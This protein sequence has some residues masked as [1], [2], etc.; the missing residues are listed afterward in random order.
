MNTKQK[1]HQAKLNQ[2]TVRFQEQA[3]SGLTVKAW[4]AENNITIHT[5]NYWKHQ[6]K[7]EYADS[8]LPDIVPLT[9]CQPVPV[10]ALPVT[11]NH[12]ALSTLQTS[13]DSRELHASNNTICIS[14][15][16]IQIHI[17]SSVSV[18]CLLQILKA[19]R[20]A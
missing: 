11:S 4:C 10:S 3:S 5:Y 7:L 2:W 14:T 17:G 12:Q 13:C 15:K 8:I 16:D 9:A 19:V 20:H 1:I 18:E 6:L